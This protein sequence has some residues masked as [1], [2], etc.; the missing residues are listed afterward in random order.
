MPQTSGK[1]RQVVIEM[2]GQR[3]TA[4]ALPAIMRCVEDADAGVRA[5][6]VD[7]IGSMGDEKHAADLVKALQ[8]TADQQD[9]AAIEKALMSI[10]GR[11][12]TACVAAL[13]P[14]AKSGDAGLRVIAVHA[15]ACAGGPDALAAVKAA[16]DDKDETVQ[17]EAVRTLSTWPN[18]WPDDAAAAAP[19]LAVAKSAKKPA[20]QVLALRGYMQYVQGAKKVSADERLARVKEALP[21]V[22]RP[23]EKRLAISVLGGIAAAGSLEM[24]AAFAADPATAE[25]ACSAIANLAAK[26]EMRSAPKE[27]RQKA[28]QTV[29][30]KSKSEVTRKKAEEALKAVR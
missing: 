12:K 22:T 9:R 5:A 21:L 28:L 7:A 18:R 2:A 27:L 29:V 17:D 14:V 6:A 8:K 19:L 1:M 3:R 30:D 15:L 23:E 13:M 24:L 10:C 20:N 16:V 11:A 25:E 4:A 26:P